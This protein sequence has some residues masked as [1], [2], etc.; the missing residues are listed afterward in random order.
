MV[1]EY[2]TPPK[3]LVVEHIELQQ[4]ILALPAR[5]VNNLE[6]EGCL[7]PKGAKVIERRTR[8]VVDGDGCTTLVL[9]A[10]SGPHWDEQEFLLQASGATHTPWRKALVYQTTSSKPSLTYCT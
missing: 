5:L 1:A 2:R 4:R 7:F 3:K 9:D 6:I 8:N 10:T